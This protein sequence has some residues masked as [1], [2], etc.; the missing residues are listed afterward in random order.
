MFPIFPVVEP[1]ATGLKIMWSAVLGEVSGLITKNV[2]KSIWNVLR[3]LFIFLLIILLSFLESITWD[4]FNN[5][6]KYWK[7]DFKLDA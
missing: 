7:K 6:R 3:Y 4:F 2:A 5:I 1:T